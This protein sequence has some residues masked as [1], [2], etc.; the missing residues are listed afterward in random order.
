MKYYKIKL[1][2]DGTRIIYP[3]GYV[4]EID[5][6]NKAILYYDIYPDSFKM[7]VLPDDVSFQDSNVTEITYEEAVVIAD[8]HAPK[9]T[10]VTDEGLIR[11]IEIKSRLGQTLSITEEKAIDLDDSTPGINWRQ[12]LAEKLSELNVTT[13]GQIK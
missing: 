6:L 10:I 12:S 7:V 8:T 4:G 1:G 13:K 11:L 9:K 2:R 5:K 3:E